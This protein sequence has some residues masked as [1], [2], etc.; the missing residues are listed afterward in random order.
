MIPRFLLGLKGLIIAYFSPAIK[1]ECQ[2]SKTIMF[3]KRISKQIDTIVKKKKKKKS[4]NKRLSFYYI[5]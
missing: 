3:S 5:N 2:Q 4:E 1:N